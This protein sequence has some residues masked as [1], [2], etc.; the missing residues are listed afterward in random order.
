MILR[1]L[2][3]LQAEKEPFL[4]WNAYVNLI[5]TENYA[6]LDSIQRPAHLVFWYE[7][8]VQNGGHLQY[9]ENRG[10]HHLGETIEV[11]GLLGAS[12]QQRILQ[13]AA[14]KYLGRPR[15]RP[16]SVEAFCAKALE[17]E[18]SAF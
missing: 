6:D 1:T 17:D 3:K 15:R 2:T 7:S 4:V 5:A 12:C 11:L 10:S 14:D 13:E 8:E 16:H 9:F 18:F